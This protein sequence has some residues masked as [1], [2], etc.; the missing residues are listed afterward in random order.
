MNA[1]DLF[2]LVILVMIFVLMGTSSKSMSCKHLKR[3]FF[4]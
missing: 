2:V 1:D 3:V 4:G